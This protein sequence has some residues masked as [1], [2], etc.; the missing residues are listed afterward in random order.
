MFSSLLEGRHD[1]TV[2]AVDPDLLRVVA[3]DELRP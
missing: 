3:A 1:A 2:D